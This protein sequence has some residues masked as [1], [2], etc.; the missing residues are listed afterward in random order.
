[1]ILKK[2]YAFL[3]KYFKLIHLICLSLITIITYNFQKIVSF[4]SNYNNTTTIGEKAGSTYISFIFLLLCLI[5]VAFFIMMYFLMRKKD[6]P[7]KFYLLGSI[8][9]VVLFLSLIYGINTLNNLYSIT[10]DIKVFRA[11]HDIYLI[12]YLPNFFFAIMSFIRG[13]GFDIKKFNFNKDLAE[14]EINSEDNEEF[15]FVLGT[16][17]YVIKRK[18]RRYFRELKYYFIENKVLV[19]II[20]FAGAII[21]LISLFVNRT[22][23]NK[24]YH[25]GDIIN[26]SEFTIKLNSAYITAKDYKGNIIKE[27]KKYVILNATISSTKTPSKSLAPEYIYMSL[28]K[29]RISNIKTTLADSFKDLGVSY[30]NFKIAEK[31]FTYIF[32]FEVD[33]TKYSRSYDLNFFDGISYDKDNNLVYNYKVAKI[34]PED[35]DLNLKIENK[36][37]N[38]TFYLG[39]KIYGDTKLS[40]IKTSILDKYE[41]TYDKCDNETC[42]PI[43]DVEFPDNNLANSLLVLNYNITAD[44]NN[45]LNDANM[46]NI[47]TKLIKLKYKQNDEYQEE[48]IVSKTNSNLNNTLLIDIPKYIVSSNEI[49][50]VISS[51]ENNYQIK[52]K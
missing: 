27:D 21:L 4:F 34:K 38:D 5:V 20:L 7:N 41:F 16:D 10:M 17:N 2:P 12:L 32:V 46:T 33:K 45:G 22:I 14:L 1:M 15:E 13:F 19:S 26:T 39:S 30:Q 36:N 51:R 42:I 6:K 49:Y 8:Y 52:I 9:Y 44:N 37:L 28:G 25:I 40:I 48:A 35:I 18:I 29:Y 23:V 31:A 11:L 43:T 47:L 24:I 50:I 3:I